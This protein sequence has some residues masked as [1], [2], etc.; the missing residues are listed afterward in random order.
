MLRKK[1]RMLSIGIT[2]AILL[3]IGA[4]FWKWLEVNTDN[5]IVNNFFSSGV[6]AA[7]VYAL[8]AAW[9]IL[10]LYVIFLTIFHRQTFHHLKF[11][12]NSLRG[13]FFGA[14]STF[15]FLW[16][17]QHNS[18]S[19]TSAFEV[20]YIFWV[21]LGQVFLTRTVRSFLLLPMLLTI[22]GSIAVIYNGSFHWND[23]SIFGILLIIFPANLC[24]AAEE[25]AGE[26]GA[27]TTQDPLGYMLLQFFYTAVFTTLGLLV[28]ALWGN[29]GQLLLHAFSQGN[30]LILAGVGAL[31]I[32]VIGDWLSKTIAKMVLPTS[33]VVIVQSSYV[34]LSFVSTYALPGLFGYP[35]A[36]LWQLRLSGILLIL[37]GN[38][39]ILLLRE[40]QKFRIKR[41]HLL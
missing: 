35:P 32:F 8:Y 12:W 20:T 11:E 24:T 22:I 4:A 9:G 18:P 21:V 13:G 33:K 17:N 38:A 28:F 14:V 30:M 40:K 7:F 29:N 2:T 1:K 31:G 41:A 25:L 39:A 15:F 23:I 6:I 5:V 36:D 27:R 10:F 19:I 34:L 37:I 3:S 26:R 16:A